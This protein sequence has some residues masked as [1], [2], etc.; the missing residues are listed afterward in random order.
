MPGNNSTDPFN[1]DAAVARLNNDNDTDTDSSDDVSTVHSDN[2]TDTVSNEPTTV[3]FSSRDEIERVIDTVWSAPSFR[4]HQ[5]TAIIDILEALYIDDNDVVSLSA[6]TGAGKSLIIYTVGRVISHVKRAK[7]FVTTP[8]NSLIDQID[9]DEYIDNITTIKGKNN[10]SCVHPRDEGTSVDD[11][12]CQRQ[13]DFDCEFKDMYDTNDGCPYYGRKERAKDTDIAVTNLS[14]LMSNAMIPETED[15]RFEPRNFLAVDETQNIEDFALNFIGFTIDR[16]E[17]PINFNNIS[18]MPPE[19]CD[20]SEMVAWLKEVLNGIRQR[21]MDLQKKG[22]LTTTENED[23]DD[24]QSLKHRIS[25]FIEDYDNN[26]HWT[27]TY[28]GSSIKFEPIMI[29]RFIDRFL[30]SQSEKILLSSATIPKGDFLDAV[31]LDN[32]DT[33]HVEVPSTFDKKNR[34]VIT[35]EMVGKMT[36][37]ERASTIPKMADKIA[38]I[39]DFHNPKNGFVHCHSYDVMERLYDNLPKYVQRRTTKQDSDNRMRSLKQWYNSEKQIFMSVSM[40]EGISLDDDRARWQVLAKASYPFMGD[41]RVNYR[42]NE[43]NDWE[44]YSNQ[45]IINLQ[46]A[47]GRGMRS[48]DD[49]CISY[50]LDSSFQSLLDRNKDLFESWFLESVDC[51]TE[52]DYYGQPDTDFTFTT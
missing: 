21:L 39:A 49:W 44:W 23:Q 52:R 9:D 18:N 2:A 34:P 8:L 45:A 6:P 3:S 15:A 16:R 14:Y 30:W 7:S 31:G 12:I 37:G 20:M 27:K 4:E 46:Q 51:Y 43:M 24:L 50:L 41:E 5:K 35:R 26:H 1:V 28:D 19:D 11:A 17:I 47:V 32:L 10:Y 36:K 22:M 29:G 25:N 33:A 13:A 38:E 40:N 42:V 48:K